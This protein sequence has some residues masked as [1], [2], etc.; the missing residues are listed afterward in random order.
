MVEALATP[1]ALAFLKEYQAKAGRGR[2]LICWAIIC[3]RSPMATCRCCSRRW[4]A[5]RAWISKSWP[6]TCASHTF[7]TVVGDVKFGP[8]GEWTEARVLEVQFRNMKSNDVDQFKDP[9]VEVIL[10]P[11]ALKNGDL[12]YPYP[13]AK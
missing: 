10:Y 12:V 4:R 9:K 1:E 2:A 13:G 7:K 8:N 11:P 5:P 6:T 3:R